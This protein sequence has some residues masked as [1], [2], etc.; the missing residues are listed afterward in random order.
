MLFRSILHYYMEGAEER[1]VLRDHDLFFLMGIAKEEIG[2][3]EE[4]EIHFQKYILGDIMPLWKMHEDLVRPAYRI[5]MLALS[6]GQG[7]DRFFGEVFYDFGEG[8]RPES[9]RVMEKDLDG[10]GY[11]VLKVDVPKGTKCIRLDPGDNPC[12]LL[13]KDARGVIDSGQKR[14]KTYPLKYHTNGNISANGIFLFSEPDPQIYFDDIRE[15][16]AFIEVTLSLIED[17]RRIILK[18]FSEKVYSSYHAER[19]YDELERHYLAA[20]GLK[21]DLEMQVEELNRR[22]MAAEWKLHC[23]YK[24]IPYKLSKPYRML[25]SGLKR[26]IAGTPRK[27]LRF[28]TFKLYLKGKGS[29]AKAFYEKELIARRTCHIQDKIDKLAEPDV[30]KAQ[31]EEMKEAGLCFSILVPVYNTPENYLMEMIESVLAQSY[32]NYQLCIA[33]GSDKAHKYVKRICKGYADFDS[34]ICYKQLKSNERS[35]EHTSELQSR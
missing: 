31:A 30:L 23:I 27:K 3:Y 6:K 22:V 33:D 24:S 19:N 14:K 16:T 9:C 26:L 10:S 25:R 1:H 7:N 5:D 15:E 17:A 8:V 21:A 35:E 32:P 29:E 18:T 4:M 11:A 28:D 13:I 2:A 34:R 12:I 20:M